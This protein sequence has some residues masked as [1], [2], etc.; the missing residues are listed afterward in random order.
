MDAFP[1]AKPPREKVLLIGWLLHGFHWYCETN[2]STLLVTVNLIV[3]KSFTDVVVFLDTLTYNEKKTAGDKGK[4]G[5]MGQE[6]RRESVLSLQPQ[7]EGP[8]TA[9]SRRR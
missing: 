5:G 8:K 1:L 6:R 9:F 3:G 4:P 7:E 2:G